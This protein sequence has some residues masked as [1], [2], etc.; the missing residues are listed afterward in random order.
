MIEWESKDSLSWKDS[1]VYIGDKQVRQ[2]QFQSN[3]YFVAG[4][5][6]ENSRDS[7]YLGLIPEE[8]IVGVAW[9]VWKSV[10]PYTG[11]TERDVLEKYSKQLKNYE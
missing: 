2:Y 8:F 11:N 3:Y 5:K 1:K 9:K 6:T 4:D 10:D 7:R